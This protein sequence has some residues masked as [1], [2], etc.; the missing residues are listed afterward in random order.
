V[1][2]LDRMLGMVGNDQV[3]DKAVL[4]ESAR[5]N[6]DEARHNY[7]KQANQSVVVNSYNP[8]DEVLLKR[9]HG[10]NPKMNPLWVGP[11]VVVKQYGPVNWG[12]KDIATGKTKVVHH[13]L[14]KPAKVN[15]DT[16]IF[17]SSQLKDCQASL[18]CV[19]RGILHSDI[20]SRQQ[21]VLSDSL[22][23]QRFAENA[24]GM[25]GSW[26][27]PATPG[28]ITEGRVP[29]TPVRQEEARVP[30]TLPEAVSNVNQTTRSGRVSKP[31]VGSRLIDQ[32]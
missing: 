17:P 5:L 20:I 10:D 26:R 32:V 14:L 29:A 23:R 13:N 25:A 30:A 27:V 16:N 24:L 15:C 1:L 18:P 3:Y 21:A 4:R 12:I 2:P 9:T 8:G 6:K 28:L 31:V 7:Q 11:F 22:D 19:S